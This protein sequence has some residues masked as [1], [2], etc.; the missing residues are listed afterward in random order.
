MQE[1]FYQHLFIQYR[2]RFQALT[3]TSCYGTHTEGF[4]SEVDQLDAIKVRL[5]KNIIHCSHIGGYL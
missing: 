5:V 1:A 2:N 3:V 4:H